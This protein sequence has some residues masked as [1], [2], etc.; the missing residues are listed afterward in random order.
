MN[1]TV[2][3]VALLINLNSALA[4]PF[5]L[6]LII[7]YLPAFLLFVQILQAGIFQ[8]NQS[9]SVLREITFVG[10]KTTGLTLQSLY[11]QVKST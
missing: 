1:K 7:A 5:E 4:L 11:Q 8:V 9:A 10:I 2:L 3:W 6:N